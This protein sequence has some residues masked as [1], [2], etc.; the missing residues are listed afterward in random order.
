[1]CAP[2]TRRASSGC[3]LKTTKAAS[4]NFNEG[5][6]LLY[7]AETNAQVQKKEKK[8]TDKRVGERGGG[9]EKEERKKGAR[10]RVCR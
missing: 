6:G 5:L 9:G 2:R 4:G 1:M 7:G 8:E 10:I 3:W